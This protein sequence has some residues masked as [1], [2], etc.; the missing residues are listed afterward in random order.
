ML[1]KAVTLEMS[2]KPFKLNSKEYIEKVCIKLFEQWKPLTV[3]YEEVYILFWTG[4]GTEILDY[5]GDLSD[6]IEWAKYIGRANENET[7]WDKIGDP[8]RIGPHARRYEYIKNPPVFTYKDLKYINDTIKK[9]GTDMLNKP[10]KVGAIFDPGPEFAVSDFKYERHPEVC[11]SESMGAGSFLVSYE[12]LNEDNF[13]YKSYPNGIP[14]DTPFATFLG[15]QSQEFLTDINF[16]YIWLSNGFGFGAENWS[17]IGP[18]FDGTKFVDTADGVDAI[19]DKTHEFWE[20]F[21]KECPDFQIQTRGTNLSV[22]IDFATDGVAIGDIYNGNYNILP[23][24]NS[25]WAALDKNFGLELAGYM[26]RIAELPNDRDF[27][28]RYYLHD[29]WWINSPWFDRY[30]G[31]PHDIYL[32]LGVSRLDNKLDIETPNYVNLLTVDTSLGELPDDAAT[33][34][35]NHLNKAMDQLPDKASPIVWV[36]PFDEYQ[37]KNN[38]NYRLSKAFFEDWY[39]V[40]AINYGMPINTV[41]STNT[42]SNL[43]QRKLEKLKGSIL[44]VPVPEINDKFESTL[45]DYIN[46]GG[47]VILYGS[48]TYASENIKNM[49]DIK[50]VDSLEGVFAVSREANNTFNKES[51]SNTLYHNS[52]ISDGGINTVLDNTSNTIKLTE[53]FQGEESRVTTVFKKKGKGKVGWLRGANSSKFKKGS[54]LLVPHDDNIYIRSELQLRQMLDNFG[55]HISFDR[56]DDISHL[57]VMGIHRFNNAFIVSGY[58]RDTTVGI[59]MLFSEGVPVLIGHEVF[60]EDYVGTYNFPRSFS[61]ECRVFVKQKSGRVS[62]S[63]YGP[64]SMT[65]KRRIL[66]EGLKNADVIIYPEEGK[67]DK[68][69]VLLNSQKPNIIGDKVDYEIIDTKYGKA[70]S[71]KNISGHLMISM[72]FDEVNYLEGR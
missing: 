12:V 28:F 46:D 8:D 61:R 55:L 29:P 7:D 25:P 69:E 17:T 13:K 26:S 15:K 63:E 35:I 45:I 18:L 66:L 37:S 19:K 60:I 39:I 34:A 30:E 9:I 59:N 51:K 42:F 22:G 49:I 70:V 71:V 56:K 72:E 14:Q 36:Y 40:S 16:D 44:I 62:M 32:P 64:V 54:N 21:R 53:V 3:N 48:L 31:E 50:I 67:S 4:D 24:P 5:S 1:K 65:M 33:F 47:E 20:L 6:E 68:L 52:L 23:P 58:L 43:S 27:M 10:I 38:G 57:P 2:F 11:T 41:V